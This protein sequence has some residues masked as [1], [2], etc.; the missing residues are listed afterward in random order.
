MCGI[1]GVIGSTFNDLPLVAKVM[2]QAMFNRGPDGDGFFLDDGIALGMRRLSIIDLLHGWQP[3]YA[4]NKRIVAFQN[5]EIY[6]HQNLRGELESKGYVFLTNSDTEVLAHG[7]DAWGIAGLLQRIDGMY[8][9]AILDLDQ[10]M[11]FLGRDRFGEKPL[12]YCQ[13]RDW[14]AYSSNLLTLAAL[15]GIDAELDSQ[16]LDRYLALHFVPGERTIFKGIWRVSPG[17]YLSVPLDHLGN[18]SRARYFRQS[19]GKPRN[20]SEDALAE[21]VEHAVQSRL[22]A[23]VGVGVFLSGGLDSSIVAA[24]AAK[25]V[26]GI[27]TF[28]MGFGSG[29]HD[30]SK[31]A[32]QVADLID[33]NHHHFTFDC[34][35]FVHLLPKVASALDEPIGDQA[36]LPLYWL[37]HEASRHVK[38]A[39]AGEGADE[40]FAGYSYY[41]DFSANP[42][43]GSYFRNLFKKHSM[44]RVM[45]RL[46][47]NATPISPSGFPLLTDI[48]ER[49]TL[50]KEHSD[51]A[52]D[53]W[54][55]S[56]MEWLESAA[57][58]L[59]RATATDLATWLPDDLLVKFDRMGMAHSLEGR[60]PFLMPG[61]VDAAL[62][63]P[64]DQRVKKGTSKIALRQIAGRW[65]PPNILTRRKQGFVLP[66]RNWITRWF[67]LHG[68][69]A[70]YLIDRAIPGLNMAEVSR[71]M[72]TD[73]AAGVQRERLLFAFVLL[74][75]WH[76][77]AQTRI[78]RLR[79]EYT[80]RDTNYC[81]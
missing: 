42:G 25:Q 22:V 61:L 27:S 67:T 39:L 18:I 53:D 64:G 17:E 73:L 47:Q 13:H 65:L 38:V 37:C 44:P 7:F 58:S 43:L 59:Q 79:R 1:F 68:G 3:L 28:S 51:Y 74:F 30:E 41:R 34:D 70:A 78:A 54:E 80:N 56:L 6:N 8:A 50:V 35:R 57:D 9:T 48:K 23:D 4:R 29:E 19:L 14:F 62:H 20:I 31:Y 75:E 16:G 26:P 76:A 12:F 60:A 33:S 49:T 2:G 72:E 46:I 40:I 52:P 10:R 45:D 11:L 66:M 69:V 63:L 81:Q 36:T 21:L 15:P 55:H 32:K 71:L 5:G 77:T 24:I